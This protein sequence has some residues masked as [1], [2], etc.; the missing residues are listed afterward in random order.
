MKPTAHTD[1][2]PE[3]YGREFKKKGERWSSQMLIE[4][5]GCSELRALYLVFKQ[6]AGIEDAV[7][8]DETYM[9]THVIQCQE[10]FRVTP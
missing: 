4:E 3:Y 6:E 1:Y 5:L 9:N 7:C 10:S 8:P 2:H